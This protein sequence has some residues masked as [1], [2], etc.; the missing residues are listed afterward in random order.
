MKSK[1]PASVDDTYGRHSFRSTNDF[2]SSIGAS[3]SPM[4]F[5]RVGRSCPFFRT[6]RG[7]MN[8]YLSPSI[9]PAEW[10]ISIRGM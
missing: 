2:S 5:A 8:I 9:S 10:R 6:T 1:S 4:S 7:T 3:V